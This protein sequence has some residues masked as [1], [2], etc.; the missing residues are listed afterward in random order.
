MLTVHAMINKEVTGGGE[1]VVG[2][3]RNRRREDI[4]SELVMLQTLEDVSMQLFNV[5]VLQSL[6]DN[7]L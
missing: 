6:V 5:N 1:G 7:R 3:G 2:V 4:L